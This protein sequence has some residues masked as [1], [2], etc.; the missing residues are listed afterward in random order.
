ME[1]FNT[2]GES[3]GELAL[4]ESVR[5]QK[6]KMFWVILLNDDYTPMDFVILV[7]MDIF[8]KSLEEATKLMWDVHKKGRGLCGLYPYSVA[9]T[10]AHLVKELSKKH[11]HPLECILKPADN[12]T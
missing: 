1:P 10:K 8:H 6:P 2:S 9:Q 11:K 5:T 3:D 4:D 7:L 12:V